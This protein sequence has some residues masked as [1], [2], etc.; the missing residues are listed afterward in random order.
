MSDARDVLERFARRARIR[1]RLRRMTTAGAWALVALAALFVGASAMRVSG[2]VAAWTWGG[3]VAWPVLTSVASALVVA[4]SLPVS[5]RRVLLEVDRRLGLQHLLVTGMEVRRSREPIRRLLVR[6]AAR[7]VEPVRV[8]AALPLRPPRILVL[9]PALAMLAW[10][11]G[12]RATPESTA[13]GL[14]HAGIQGERRSLSAALQQL[15]ARLLSAREHRGE[16]GVRLARQVLRIEQALRS[17]A[18]DMARARSALLDLA[19]VAPEEASAVLRA[20]AQEDAEHPR[21][22]S[23]AGAKGTLSTGSPPALGEAGP[24]LHRPPGG[25]AATTQGG[26]G[27]GEGLGRASL[28]VTDAMPRARQAETGGRAWRL[29]AAAQ[30]GGPSKVEPASPGAAPGAPYPGRVGS[31]PRRALASA[32]PVGERERDLVQAYLRAL[33]QLTA[34]VAAE[35]HGSSKGRENR[36]PR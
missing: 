6:R 31:G 26:A 19:E 7:R 20:A 4:A 13:P 8:A 1:V 11:I 14:G 23:A 17:N 15:A 5:S 12:V 36:G 28:L 3:W 22:G 34:G 25:R 10:G 32:R 33:G 21:M 27:S 9:L 18:M 16:E 35:D 30:E 24:G 29:P 2:W